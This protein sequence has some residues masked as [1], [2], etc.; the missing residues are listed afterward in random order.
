MA[1]SNWH[2]HNRPARFRL[3]AAALISSIAMTAGCAADTAGKK[4][5][6]HSPT[7]TGSA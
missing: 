6:T 3:I 1:H 5:R 2:Q 4:G 7:S